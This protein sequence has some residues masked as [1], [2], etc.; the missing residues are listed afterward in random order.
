MT[1]TTKATAAAAATCREFIKSGGTLAQ[2]LQVYGY[3]ASQLSDHDLALSRANS[4]E[5]ADVMRRELARLTGLKQPP[6][7]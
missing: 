1:D 3:A 4:G 6:K 2:W 5:T 7:K